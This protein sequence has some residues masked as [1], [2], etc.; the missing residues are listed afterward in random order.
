MY[1]VY[2]LGFYLISIHF[3]ANIWLLAYLEKR[4]LRLLIYLIGRVVILSKDASPGRFEQGSLEV[5]VVNTNRQ[6]ISPGSYG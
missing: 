4:N 3:L 2:C 5:V 6:A 1:Q